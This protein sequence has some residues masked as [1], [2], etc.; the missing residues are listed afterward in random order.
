MSDTLAIQGGPPIRTE[1]FPEWPIFGDVERQ[2]LLQALESGHWGGEG[3]MEAEF[4]QKFAEFC[5]AKHALC[6]S[7]GSV[8]LELI[9]KALGIGPG[10][11]VIVPALTWLATAWAPIQ[12]GATPVFADITHG[13]WC[14]DPADVRRKITSRTKAIIPVHLYSQI[15]SMTELMTIAREHKLYVVEDC[16]HTHGSEWEGKPVGAIGDAGSYSFQGSKGMTAG[17]GG[18]IVT[19]SDAIADRIYGLKNCGRLR[20]PDS[21]YT[22]GSNN[23]MTEFQSAV[24]LG[25]LQRLPAL[26]ETR[27]ENIAYLRSELHKIE[28]VHVLKPKKSV[29]R[30]GL[31]C[32]SVTIDPAAFSGMPRD[33]LVDTMQAEGIPVTAPYEV[34]YR[35]VLWKPSEKYWA[36]ADDKSPRQEL[37]LDAKCPVS[38]EVAMRTGLA[39]NH[40]LFLGTTSDMDDIVDAFLK[41]QRIVA[42]KALRR[43]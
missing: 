23:R 10:D 5:G 11:E 13:D 18:A 42:R 25:Q 24:L 40:R 12:V 27:A 26:M 21:P 20:T 19:N 22:F 17:E 38:E 28:G 35:S 9:L 6:V 7:N 16:A 34:V 33:L 3:P 30:Q 36:F 29:T 37:G 8:T 2:G 14:L 1:S 43:S 41:I 32:L 4:S 15:A 39:F 31:Y